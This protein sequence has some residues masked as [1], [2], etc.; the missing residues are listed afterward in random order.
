M[1]HSKKLLSAQERIRR[2]PIGWLFLLFLSVII[3]IGATLPNLQEWMMM[4][5]FI[6]TNERVVTQLE[7][8]KKQLQE[9]YKTEND[10]LQKLWEINEKEETQRFPVHI[11]PHKIANILEVY[12]LQ[13]KNLTERFYAP[14]FELQS[15]H[16]GRLQ[17]HKNRDTNDAEHSTMDMSLEFESDAQ[18]FTDFVQFL[19]NGRLS[20]RMQDGF[21]K[22]QIEPEEHQF[23]ID[24][25]L[26]VLHVDSIQYEMIQDD[27]DIDETI[28]N[29]ERL[30]ETK[31]RVSMNIQLYS[32]PPK[33]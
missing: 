13:L 29:A 27:T 18:N 4:R 5:S 17:T 15:V 10:T 11:D 25:I 26:P 22:E 23:L 6:K 24:N 3:L 9:D 20:N 2:N 16:F 8:T 14:Y 32:Q 7:T 28:P 31:F 21:K 1:S 33:N 12:A 19:Q 30:E